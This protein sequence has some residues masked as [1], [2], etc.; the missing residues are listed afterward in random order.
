MASAVERVKQD[1]E[2]RGWRS[3]NLARVTGRW[4]PILSKTL[5]EIHGEGGHPDLLASIYDV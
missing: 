2:D 1:M 4:L 3:A 5:D